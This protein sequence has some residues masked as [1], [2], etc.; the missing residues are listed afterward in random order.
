MIM[1]S[2]IFYIHT[3]YRKSNTKQPYI[4]CK[5]SFHTTVYILF[6]LKKQRFP[7]RATPERNVF[8][9][10]KVAV[11]RNPEGRMGK[12]LSRLLLII[13]HCNGCNSQVIIIFAQ[14]KRHS[15]M[16]K[17]GWRQQKT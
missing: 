5:K 4:D 9:P 13:P 1:S 6:R 11:S 15:A 10:S 14:D 16:C 2:S 7:S 3:Q 12:A 8:M 17:T